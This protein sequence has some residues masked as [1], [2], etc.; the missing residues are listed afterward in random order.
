MHI[1]DTGCGLQKIWE[2]EGTRPKRGMNDSTQ[3][4]WVWKEIIG[5]T[6][7]ALETAFYKLSAE[8]GGEITAS[9]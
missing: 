2:Q 1:P 7:E 3:D 5:V 4:K 9:L 8:T 6:W